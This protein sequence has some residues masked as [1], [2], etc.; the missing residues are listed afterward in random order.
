[1]AQLLDEN[2]LFSR[3]TLDHLPACYRSTVATA[4]RQTE[5]DYEV[6]QQLH[7]YTVKKVKAYP[8]IVHSTHS[9][10]NCLIPSHKWTV[11]SFQML[12]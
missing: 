7:G 1:M 5:V 12:C 6:G 2:T 3:L 4:Q 11:N 9:S 8:R 10:C